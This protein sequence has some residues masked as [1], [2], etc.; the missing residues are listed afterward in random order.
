MNKTALKQLRNQMVYQTWEEKKAE[1]EMKDIAKL[2]KISI[3]Q[4]Y[5]IVKKETH[6]EF[7]KG[8]Q[9]WS[10]PHYDFPRLSFSL[11]FL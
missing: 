9:K 7:F 4:V 3:P 5:R 1:W 8:R 2:F 6:K 11:H 10:W